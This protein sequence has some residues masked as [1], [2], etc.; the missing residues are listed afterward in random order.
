MDEVWLPIG[1]YEGLYSVSNLGRIRSEARTCKAGFNK[2]RKVKERIMALPVCHS[3]HGYRQVRLNRDNGGRTFLVHLLVIRTFVGEPPEGMECAH[4]DGDRT[5]PALSN[6]EW[7]THVEN[8]RDK[9]LHGT[10]LSGEKCPWSKLTDEQVAAIRA[11]KRRQWL[12]AESY[13]MSQCQISRIIGRKRRVT[14]PVAHRT[15]T[16]QDSTARADP[17]PAGC[18]PS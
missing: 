7:K 6:L 10:F 11:D 15:T 4:L 16:P 17:D 3:D 9:R 12:I 18:T 5:N 8:E 13:G 2:I 1:G 14:Q